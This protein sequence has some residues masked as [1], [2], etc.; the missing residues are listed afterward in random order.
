MAVARNASGE[1]K[2]SLLALELELGLE[3]ELDN[4]TGIHGFAH[5][6]T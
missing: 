3:L 1:K 6:G 2:L 5:P 4:G